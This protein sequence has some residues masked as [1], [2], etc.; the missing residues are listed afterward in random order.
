MYILISKH[1]SYCNYS[2]YFLPY[3]LVR[4]H[5][6]LGSSLSQECFKIETILF[7]DISFIALSM[8]N[9]TFL[10]GRQIHCKKNFLFLINCFLKRAFL[11][12]YRLFLHHLHVNEALVFCKTKAS[13]AFSSISVI[14]IAEGF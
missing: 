14:I 10:V 9:F 2:N 1:K 7:N 13:T 3:N 12:K 6:I 8:Q 5:S 4:V 11:Q